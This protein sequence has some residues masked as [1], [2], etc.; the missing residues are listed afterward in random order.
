MFS[1]LSLLGLVSTV[2]AHGT[3]SG[4]VADGVYYDGYNPSYQ[5]ITPAPVTVGWK[6]PKDLDNGFI[7]PNNFATA[8][9][10]CHVGATNAMAAA[11]VKAGGKIEYQWTPWPTSHKGPIIEYLANCNGPCETVDKTKLLWT[12]ISATG[13]IN[14]TSMTNGYWAT[15]QMIANN[16]SWTS[17]IP[18]NIATGNY[19]LRHEILALHAAGQANGAQD[20]PQCFNLAITGTGTD[21]LTSGVLGTALMKA[22]DPGVLF[23]LYSA[24]T[25]YTIPGPALYS[26]AVTISQ[27]LPAAPTA[28]ATGVYTV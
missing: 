26:G 17:V 1:K 12:K 27:T 28:T 23:D 24:F 2:V 5:Y 14:P 22:T 9:M 20:Y 4:I 25:S 13:L 21:K 7:A 6:I 11:P 16:N 10:I 18:A 3:V 19:V 8:D 15:D